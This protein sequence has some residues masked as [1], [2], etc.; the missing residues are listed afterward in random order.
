MPHSTPYLRGNMT[1]KAV[2]G[3]ELTV[4]LLAQNEAEARETLERAMNGDVL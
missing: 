3:V 4:F 2:F 1:T